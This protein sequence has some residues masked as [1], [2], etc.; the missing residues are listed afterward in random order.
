MRGQQ[1]DQFKNL[2][3]F[4]QKEK[5]EQEVFEIKEIKELLQEDKAKELRKKQKE[6]ED[7]EMF[8]KLNEE[9]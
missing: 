8:R 5:A 6:I 2:R 1:L 9:R 4:N 7:G 3:R